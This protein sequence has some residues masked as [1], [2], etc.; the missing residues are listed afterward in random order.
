MAETPTSSSLDVKIKKL[1]AILKALP[2]PR[3]WT[4]LQTLFGPFLLRYASHLAIIGLVV[5]T[6][7]L[8]GI[9]LPRADSPQLLPPTAAPSL[10]DRT[11]TA[12]AGRGNLLPAER[13]TLVRFPVPHTTIPDRLRRGVITYTVQSGDMVSSIAADFGLKWTTIMWSNEHL[14]DNPDLLL[15]GQVLNILPIDGAYHRVCDG[16]TLAKIAKKYEVEVEDITG[17]PFNNVHSDADLQVGVHLLVPGGRKPYVPVVFRPTY[18]GPFPADAPRGTG[19]FIW[20]A[21]GRLTDLFGYVRNRWHTGIDIA[22]SQGTHVFAADRGYV[23]QAGWTKM[24]YGVLV[25][26]DHGNGYWTYYGHLSAVWVSAGQYVEQGQWVGNIGNTGRSTGPHLHFEIR[27]NK[28]PT[29]PMG[30]LPPR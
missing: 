12:L 15:P 24:G 25:I 26:I 1:P 5:L 17:C 30:L 21:Q 29:D 11:Y 3:V 22:N 7:S 4:N 27:R 10:G 16:D 23:R 8:S 14:E 20:P 13:S 9:Q 19:Q 2:R 28:E 6:L 18:T